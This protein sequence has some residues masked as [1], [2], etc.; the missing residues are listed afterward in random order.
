MVWYLSMLIGPT[1]CGMTSKLSRVLLWLRD[2]IS[3][4]EH[5]TRATGMKTNELRSD[6]KVSRNLLVVTCPRCVVG[7]WWEPRRCSPRPSSSLLDPAHR[8]PA[9]SNTR[10]TPPATCPLRRRTASPASCHVTHTKQSKTTKKSPDSVSLLCVSDSLCLH[11]PG[12][13]LIAVEQMRFEVR[14]RHLQARAP[15]ATEG[16]LQVVPVRHREH[17]LKEPIRT[18]N[19]TWSHFTDNTAIFL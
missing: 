3:G 16:A 6:F 5:R 18:L 1:C 7:W 2:N 10:Q 13:F 8:S 15:L 17:A 4:L 11:G 14:S 9:E 12:F 19:H